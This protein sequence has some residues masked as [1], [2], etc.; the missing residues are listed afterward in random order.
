MF[1]KLKWKIVLC[2]KK[3]NALMHFL[4]YRKIIR[5]NIALIFMWKWKKKNGRMG[6]VNIKNVWVLSGDEDG[7]EMWVG[8]FR[9]RKEKEK[10]KEDMEKK[11]NGSEIEIKINGD[12]YGKI[13]WW[14]WKWGLGLSLHKWIE[15]IFYLPSKNR[16]NKKI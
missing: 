10:W 15:F 2:K 12:G 8:I 16:N 3:E 5:R 7:R 1:W 6:I 14:G 9:R 4:I 11:K 13:N